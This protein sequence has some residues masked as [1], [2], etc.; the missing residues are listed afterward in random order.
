[1][2]KYR[3]KEGT[4]DFYMRIIWAIARNPQWYLHV[5]NMRESHSLNMHV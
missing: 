2:S 1:M 5:S 3:R 4:T